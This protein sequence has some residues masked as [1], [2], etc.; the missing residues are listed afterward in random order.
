[1]DERFATANFF[2]HLSPQNPD[3]KYQ[4]GGGR[5]LTTQEREEIID[6]SNL[7]NTLEAP[8]PKEIEEFVFPNL[9]SILQYNRWI[10][11][12]KRKIAPGSHDFKSCMRWIS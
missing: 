1:M 2:N 7:E 3:N 4:L 10:M 8:N 12:I 11:T 9:P 5:V 6:L